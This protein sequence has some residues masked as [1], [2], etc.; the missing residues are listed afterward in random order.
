M[1]QPPK[2]PPVIRAP[3]APAARRGLDGQVDGRHGDLE[4]V[5]H[6]GVRGVSSGAR[7][8][9]PP[10]P[11]QLDGL[12]HP[13][14]LGDHVPDPAAHHLVVGSCASAASRSVTSRSAGTP[15][16]R[17]AASSQVARRVGVL[18]VDEGVRGVGVEHQHLQARPRRGRAAPARPRSS[19]SRRT[20]RDP[21]VHSVEAAWSMSP[22]GA[23][24]NSFSARRASFARSSGS[25]AS[26]PRSASAVSVAHS[27][28]AEED[29]PA[30]I[31]HVR[32]R[33]PGRRRRRRGPASRERPDHPG[34]VRVPAG[35]AR[36]R[37]SSG[38][39]VSVSPL[40]SEVTRQRVVRAGAGRDDD[41][42]RQRERHHEAVVVV[43]VLAD[44]VDPARR[45]PDPVRVAPVPLGEGGRRRRRRRC[46]TGEL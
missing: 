15:E 33:A 19:G 16:Q 34:D 9:S 7:S 38:P 23:P 45:G 21:P 17:A 39:N 35:H 29:S 32:G 37:R 5:A 11:Q 14:V 4:V 40:L 2:P 24:T 26:P 22:V 6:R 44:Q 20:G 27:S 1:M 12:Q 18:A 28:A 30:P 31:G 3:S 42:L 8:R 43:G 25:M 41:P 13:L 36:A 10:A 46:L